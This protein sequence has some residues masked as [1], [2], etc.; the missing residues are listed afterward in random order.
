MNQQPT[1]QYPYQNSAREASATVPAKKK[2][3]RG[4]CLTG[5]LVMLFIFL[6]LL[7]GGGIYLYIQSRPQISEVE[8]E[9]KSIP[10]YYENH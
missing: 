10:D 7:I 1:T 4:C 9:Y 8:K 3:K 5:C 6:T 2:K